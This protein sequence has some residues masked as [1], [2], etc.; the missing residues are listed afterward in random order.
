MASSSAPKGILSTSS[1][2]PTASS[3][4]SA[5][6]AGEPRRARLVGP[7]IVQLPDPESDDETDPED[8]GGTELG[9]QPRVQNKD[10]LREFGDDT[11]VRFPLAL[12]PY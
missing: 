9:G 3:S 6:V 12:A 2:N 1:N 8:E 7:E 11:E 10:T 5:V 4:S